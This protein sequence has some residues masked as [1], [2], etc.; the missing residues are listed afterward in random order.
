MFNRLHPRERERALRAMIAARSGGFNPSQLDIIGAWYAMAASAPVSSE[1]ETIVDVLGGASLTQ[2]DADRKLAS[3]TSANGLPIGTYD[4]SDCISMPLG[5]NN[6][7]TSKFGLS[8]WLSP[9]SVTA[10]QR[11]FSIFNNDAG[12]RVL[13]VD[14][15]NPGVLMVSVYIGSNLDGRIYTTAN[16]VLT[17]AAYNYP[18]LQLDMTRTNECDT[19]GDDA[20]AKVRLFVGETALALTPSSFGTGG[21]LTALRSPTGSAI[22]GGTANLDTPGA[23]LLN[24]SIHGPNTFIWLDTPTA[25]QAANVMNFERPT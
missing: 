7:N 12:V 10:T 16:G 9:A 20:D 19:T 24:G 11:I 8:L 13:T 25:Q 5:A 2:T 1:W 3:G 21:T 23:P 17:A 4:G 6:F 14:I 22:W 15:N 18:R